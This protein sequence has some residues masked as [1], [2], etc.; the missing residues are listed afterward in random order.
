M[1]SLESL[2]TLEK[3]SLT[4]PLMYLSVS[5]YEPVT[6]HYQKLL[7]TQISEEFRGTK[8]KLMELVQSDLALEVFGPN[9]G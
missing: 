2:L 8:P 4:G 5:H 6:S 3:Y 7:D 9:H 1:V